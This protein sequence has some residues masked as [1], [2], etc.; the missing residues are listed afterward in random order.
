VPGVV[1][2]VNKLVRVRPLQARY[3]G[4]V[5]DVVVGRVRE[6]GP[7]QWRV[8]IR[9]RQDALLHL[10]MVNMPGGAQRRRTFEDQL[11]MREHFREG[12]LISVS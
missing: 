6:V 3:T 8:D 2:R 5:G 4:E 1:E 11:N 7:K 10:S 12:D 9:G